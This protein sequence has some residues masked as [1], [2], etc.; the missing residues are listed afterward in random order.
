MSVKSNRHNT[1]PLKKQILTILLGTVLPI[2]FGMFIIN[3]IEIGTI[4]NQLYST[5]QDTLA[6]NM[7][8]FDSELKNIAMKMV[9]IDYAEMYINQFESDDPLE[10]YYAQTRYL[11]QLSYISSNL[12]TGYGIYCPLNNSLIYQYDNNHSVSYTHRQK[13]LEIIQQNP[14][15]LL[16]KNWHLA[17]IE[18]YW[19]LVYAY[20]MRNTFFFCWVEID[21]MMELPAQWLTTEDGGVILLGS[22]GAEIARDQSIQGLFLE[23]P[24]HG[25]I[26]SDGYMIFG[27]KSSTNAYQL[28]EV[29][30]IW[31]MYRPIRWVLTAVILVMILFV[32]ELIF[33]AHS[34]NRRFFAPMDQLQY[35][36]TRVNKGFL[37]Y[38]IPDDHTSIEF[39]KLI[40][41]F[42]GMVAQIQKLKVQRYEDQIE[43]SRIQM[44]YMRVQIEPH[45][46]LNALNTI[47]AMAQVGDDEL[48]QKLTRCLSDYMR[49]LASSR[50]TV[51][52]SEELKNIDNYLEIMKIRRGNSFTY[53]LNCSPDTMDI[54]IPPLLVQ[55][56]IENIMK[57][58]YNAYKETY[59]KV[60]IHRLRL[61]GRNGIQITV[62][63]NGSGYPEAFAHEFNL[64]HQVED[65]RIGLQNARTRLRYLYGEETIFHIS[66]QAGGGAKTQIWFPTDKK[67]K[68]T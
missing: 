42:N 41:S 57:Y 15:V 10:K 26:I 58:A 27:Q 47:N 30:S 33:L 28:V 9:G 8:I 13:F 56:L 45:F 18:D 38:R 55:T 61:S 64:G 52:I 36:I 14:D 49:F 17:S 25:Y 44:Q 22:N 1:M 62:T 32:I 54:S 66:N 2:F 5:S 51:T 37:D 31:E 65:N 16:K 21:Y 34:F 40:D 59:F 23:Y 68:A 20:Q 63:D 12:T 48:I 11:N 46:Y 19:Y 3:G 67:E 43:K 7:A 60:A 50:E 53:C 39:H 29:I 24:E 4:R 35:A 6:S